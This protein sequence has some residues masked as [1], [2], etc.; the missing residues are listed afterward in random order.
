VLIRSILLYSTKQK[1]RPR[2]SRRYRREASAPAYPTEE[3]REARR[4]AIFC[5]AGGI[6]VNWAMLYLPDPLA[7]LLQRIAEH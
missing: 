4:A 1:T 3:S 5:T 2:P 7:D 6:D